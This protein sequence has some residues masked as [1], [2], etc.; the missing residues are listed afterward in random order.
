MTEINKEKEHD[1]DPTAFIG[2]ISHYNLDLEYEL[3]QIRNQ[4]NRDLL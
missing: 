1:F 4:W 3:Q 2:M